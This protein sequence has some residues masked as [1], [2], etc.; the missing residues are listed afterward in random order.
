MTGAGGPMD[1]KPETSAET[2]ER[3]GAAVTRTQEARAAAKPETSAETESRAVTPPAAAAAED[4]APQAK[5][6]V[7]EDSAQPL[8]PAAAAVLWFTPGGARAAE[9]L[10]PLLPGAA[11]WQP[12]DG[13][14]RDFVRTQFARCRL[15]VF[16]GA[17]GIAVR[18]LSGL[19]A[20]KDKDPA[21]LVIDELGRY[22]IPILS[23]HLG[24]ANRM[25]ARLAA[26]LGAQCILT[27]ATDLENRFAVDSWAAAHGCAV[28]DV[29][30]IGRISAAV[31]RG[32]RVGFASDFAVSGALPE[33]LF[34]DE[35]CAAGICVSLDEAKKPFAFTLNVVPQIAVLGAGCKRGTDPAAFA[36]FAEETLA[37]AHISPRAV[38]ALASLELKKDEP[39]LLEYARALGVPLRCFSAA[40]LAAVPGS[41]TASAFVRAATGVD[42]V[43]E[44]SAALLA[45]AQPLVRKTARSG[46]TLSIAL[47]EW[48]CTF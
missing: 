37:Q 33:G 10:L 45:G 34:T 26:A 23:G 35:S 36:H 12:G 31:L 32:E 7:P 6:A 20:A 4:G 3:A 42:N 29:H 1:A 43:C 40:Q 13:P 5:A 17:A 30:G 41:F 44:R 38:C 19:P 15:L 22:V 47:R 25:A 9:T 21:V 24:G 46:M 27:T 2:G 39:C 16:I 28:A 8:L 11:C 48:K 18:L 14:V